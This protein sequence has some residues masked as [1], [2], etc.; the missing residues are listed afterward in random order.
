MT[1]TLDRANRTAEM[2]KRLWSQR[3]SFDDLPGQLRFYRKLWARGSKQKHGQAPGPGPYARFYEQ[4]VAALEAA[5]RE[6]Q[7]AE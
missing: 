1:I 7:N 2:R 4:D 5:I 6:V 3:V